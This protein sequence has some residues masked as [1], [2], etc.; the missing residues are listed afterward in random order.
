[1]CRGTVR[2]RR[3]LVAFG[4]CLSCTHPALACLAGR[5]SL[6]QA[7]DLRVRSPLNLSRRR[8]VSEQKAQFC[9]PSLRVS[10]SATRC[11]CAPCGPQKSVHRDGAGGRRDAARPSQLARREEAK[12]Q[13]DAHLAN[14]HAG[15]LQPPHQCPFMRLCS[16]FPPAQCTGFFSGELLQ[17][18]GNAGPHAHS[19]SPAGMV[20]HVIVDL[21]RGFAWERGKMA[22]VMCTL[23][24]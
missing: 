15:S 4:L 21:G 9:L 7:S 20:A 16:C 22:C 8:K 2:W 5:Q 11:T 19:V 1:M 6:G 24:V 18:C 12:V 10:V 13:R 23:A 14:L 3:M 17:I